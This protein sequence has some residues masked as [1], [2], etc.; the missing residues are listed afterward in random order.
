MSGEK[1]VSFDKWR[2]FVFVDIVKN[3]EQGF[4]KQMLSDKSS[5]K[6]FEKMS[7]WKRITDTYNL[8]TE[9]SVTRNQLQDLLARL[10][11]EAA[12]RMK[13]R[14]AER[15]YA[16]EVKRTG[17]GPGPSPL[18]G[19]FLLILFYCLLKKWILPPRGSLSSSL[20]LSSSST[21]LPLLSSSSSSLL[22]SWS[23]P[24]PDFSAGAGAGE[25][26]PGPVPAPAPSPQSS[27][28]SYAQH[29]GA[30]I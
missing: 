19:N 16:K 24:E 11:K 29:T 26:A 6:N 4:F 15:K 21:L 23:Q 5:G 25:K 14:Q 7:V 10:K 30:L 12:I 22:W 18:S 1:R 2:R 9:D 3:G 28:N 17:G 8:R 13:K 27:D 20:S